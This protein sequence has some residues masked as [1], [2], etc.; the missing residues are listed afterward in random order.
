MAILVAAEFTPAEWAAWWPALQRALPGETLIRAPVE[1]AAIDIALVANPPRGALAELP[2]LALIQSLWAGVDRLL[3][4]PSVPTEV[5]LARM[6]DPVMSQAMAQAAVWAVLS[7][8][9]G[10]FDY[11]QQQT[12]C[13]WQQ[14]A[15]RR[16]AAV[17]VAVLGL[18]AMGRAVASAL[19]ANGYRVAG[20]STRP[21][22]LD[23]VRCAAGPAGLDEVLN[24]AEI[25]INLLPLT[26]ATRG[27]F[28]R[29][30]FAAMRRGASFVNFGR[31]AHVVDADLLAALDA[32][33]LSRAVLD[34]F[35]TEPLPPTHRFW[36]HPRITLLPHVAALTDPHSAAEVVA[37]NVRALRE[38]RPLAHQ[39]DRRRGY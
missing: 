20:W 22:L 1:R 34:V 18:G 11:A 16:A 25:A 17:D 10:F 12:Q 19:V 8:H 27:L 4:D 23:G 29:T 39:I 3:A 21:A 2:Q 35:E 26:R 30:R 33:H 36:L 31:G 5:P 6:V 14:L 7:L 37:R 24:Q 9:R 13:H 38:G 32:G 28:D 15:Q